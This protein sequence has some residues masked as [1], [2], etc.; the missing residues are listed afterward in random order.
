MNEIKELPQELINKISA[1]EVIERPSSVI[2][3]LVEN[4]I[5]AKSSSIDIY[6][7]NGGK[8]EIRVLDNGLGINSKDVKLAFKRHATSK[9]SD[10]NLSK[11]STLGFRGEALSSIASISRMKIYTSVSDTVNGMS[12]EV[13]SGLIQNLKPSPRE[14]GTTIEVND[15]FFTTPARLKFLKTENYETLLIKQCIQKLALSYPDIGFNFYSNNKKIISSPVYDHN[16]FNKKLENRIISLFGSEFFKNLIWFNEKMDSYHFYGFIGLP[17]FHHSNSSKQFTFVNKRPIHDRY[18]FNSIKAAYRDFLS[19]DRFP[20]VILFIHSPFEDVDINVHP[21][22]NEVRFKNTQNLRSL[23]IRSIK[24]GLEHAGHKSSTLNTLKTIDMINKN[25]NNLNFVTEKMVNKYLPYKSGIEKNKENSAKETYQDYPLGIAKSQF[26][27]TYIISQTKN[28]IVIIDQHAAH[29]RIVYEKLKKNYNQNNLETQILLIPEIIE[30][31]SEE[32]DI[33]LNHRNF[34]ARYGLLIEKFSSESII[35]REVPLIL[36][37]CNINLLLKDLVADLIEIGDSQIL[38][39]NINKICSSMACHGSI[40]AGRLM[41]QDE[42]NK[43]LREMEATPFSGQCNHG[44]P[45]Y[46]ELNL[47]QI[48]RLFGRK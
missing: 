12:F 5:D 7:R 48:E 1:G 8:T 18:L 28:S 34:L 17:T 22:K 4:S 33:L 37:N 10:I 42:M 2:K 29:E 26:H 6:I 24:R 32:I 25:T 21:T 44:R 9:L 11:I 41:Y 45:T 15:L 13:N 31:I 43:L 40:R 27:E 30:V 39:T 36:I 16:S 46:I 14:M 35:V 19:Y 23:L 38:E 47:N 20:Q 3:E